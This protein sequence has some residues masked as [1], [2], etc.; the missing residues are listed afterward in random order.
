M[1]STKT[2]QEMLSYWAGKG[3]EEVLLVNVKDFDDKNQTG[4]YADSTIDC[5][6]VCW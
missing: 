1:V 5:Q 4:E 6:R 2:N 3:F